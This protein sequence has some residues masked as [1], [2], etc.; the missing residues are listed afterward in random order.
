MQI[1]SQEKQIKFRR[2]FLI[3]SIAV[4]VILVGSGCRAIR[5]NPKEID[6][7]GFGIGMEIEFYQPVAPV[8]AF[9]SVPLKATPASSWGTLMPMKKNK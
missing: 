1:D 6:V 4:Y 5:S 8:E 9:G 7:S 2:L 3:V